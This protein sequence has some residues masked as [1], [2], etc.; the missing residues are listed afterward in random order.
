MLLDS[1]W[2]HVR[3]LERERGCRNTRHWEALRKLM[4]LGAGF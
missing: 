2:R 4:L 3:A 1:R